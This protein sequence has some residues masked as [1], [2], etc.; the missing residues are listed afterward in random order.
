M[1][2][3][4]CEFSI[5][6]EYDEMNYNL[7]SGVYYNVFWSANLLLQQCGII[8]QELNFT[9]TIW[10]PSCGEFFFVFFN[11]N[12]KVFYN[13]FCY[14]VDES[15]HMNIVVFLIQNLKG[16]VRKYERSKS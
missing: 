8:L 7:V 6:S 11:S 14:I 1:F 16:Y 9:S 13:F 12:N 5:V 2:I 3:S 10:W 4:L 15:V